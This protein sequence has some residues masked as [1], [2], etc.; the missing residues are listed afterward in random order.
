MQGDVI[1]LF[2][3]FLKNVPLSFNVVVTNLMY[4]DECDARSNLGGD[5]T[6]EFSARVRIPVGGLQRAALM[7]LTLYI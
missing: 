3:Y 2:R 7:I 4:T 1:D 6:A 5:L